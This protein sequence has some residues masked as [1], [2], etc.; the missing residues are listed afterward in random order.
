MKTNRTAY[1]GPHL[2][3]SEYL[4]RS[5]VVAIFFPLEVALAGCKKPVVV[6]RIDISRNHEG[7]KKVP[8]V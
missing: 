6:S 4:V 7:V 8:K 5:A 2:G 1:L 3:K